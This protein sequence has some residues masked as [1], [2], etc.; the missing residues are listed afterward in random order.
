[1]PQINIFLMSWV[2]VS[3]GISMSTACSV[4]HKLFVILAGPC[5]VWRM[6]DSKTLQIWFSSW[7]QA[8]K[9]KKYPNDQYNHI[10]ARTWDFFGRIDLEFEAD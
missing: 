2:H 7:S 3:L 5:Y 9:D 1:M 6:D 4:T 8:C 10:G